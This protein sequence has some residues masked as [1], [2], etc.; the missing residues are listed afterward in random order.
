MLQVIC[1]FSVHVLPKDFVP[2]QIDQTPADATGG[3]VREASLVYVQWFDED[4]DEAYGPTGLRPLEWQ[5]TAAKKPA[6][7]V[8]TV[9]S[10]NRRVTMVPDYIK[11]ARGLEAYLLNDLVDMDAQHLA[12][13]IN[14][15][16]T[17]AVG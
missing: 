2:N 13:N 11:Q 1:I 8:I 5:L 4:L 12:N 7:D 16:S 10:I 14:F 6:Y 9:A 15:E 3:G 17:G